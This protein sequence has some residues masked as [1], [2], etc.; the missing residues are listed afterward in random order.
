[1]DRNLSREVAEQTLRAPEF[2]IPGHGG[3][4][5]FAR[6]YHDDELRREMLMCVVTE[7]NGNETIGVTVYRTSKIGKTLRGERA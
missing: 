5:I 2:R 6:R 1:V 3:R 4:T 7:R